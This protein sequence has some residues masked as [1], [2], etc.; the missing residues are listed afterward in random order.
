M[1]DTYDWDGEFTKLTT[2]KIEV[3]KFSPEIHWRTQDNDLIKYVDMDTKHLI[4][5]FRVT[6]IKGLYG[7]FINSHR[8]IF[9]ELV[10]R[11]VI[12]DQMLKEN[13]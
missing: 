1:K 6:S 4:N 3:L 13:T 11:N 5:C 8:S 9:K 2:K 7:D 12:T 10:K